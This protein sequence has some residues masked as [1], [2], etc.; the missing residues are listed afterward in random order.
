MPG[1][2]SGTEPKDWRWWSGAET[3]G[4]DMWLTLTAITVALAIG[5]CVVA[6]SV[7]ELEH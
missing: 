7:Q 2:L 6:L 4:E 5:F 1:A 3:T